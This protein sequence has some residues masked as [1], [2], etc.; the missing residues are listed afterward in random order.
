MSETEAFRI[1]PKCGSREVPKLIV[2]SAR[3]YGAGSTWQCRSC[4]H[5]W[6]DDEY[7]QLRAS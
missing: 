7:S 6:S 3:L 2:S 1:C 4:D 5:H